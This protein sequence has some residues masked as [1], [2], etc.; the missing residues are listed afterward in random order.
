MNIATFDN[1]LRENCLKHTG[2]FNW[3]AQEKEI[4]AYQMLLP[5]QKKMALLL[6]YTKYFDEINKL[7]GNTTALEKIL[8]HPTAQQDVFEFILCTT[9]VCFRRNKTDYAAYS[10]GD[11][12]LPSNKDELLKLKRQFV[13][14]KRGMSKSEDQWAR[15]CMDDSSAEDFKR[16]LDRQIEFIA[17]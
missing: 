12:M 7:D 14:L 11:Y 5:T 4:D 16:W 10:L 8:R 2:P 13:T 1:A 17:A 3:L 6:V 9:L 15:D